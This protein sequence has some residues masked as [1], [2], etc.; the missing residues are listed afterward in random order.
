LENLDM[1]SDLQSDVTW[2]GMPYFKNT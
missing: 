1:N 2:K